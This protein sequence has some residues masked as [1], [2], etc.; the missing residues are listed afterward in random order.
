MNQKFNILYID[1]LSPRGHLF[2]NKSF[3]NI[4]A[5]FSNKLDLSCR[6]GYIGYND[7]PKKIE[8]I[9]S[10]PIQYYKINSKFDYRIKNVKKIKW[11]LKNINI[12]IYDLIFISSYETISFSLAWPRNIKPRVIVV[13]HNNLDELNDKIKCAFFKFIPKYVEH[14]VFEDYMRNYLLKEIKIT[15]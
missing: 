5:S 10:I 6:E 11:V 8:R 14:V 2:L 15:A 3:L 4:F 13:D 1:L 9:Y 12:D 7:I